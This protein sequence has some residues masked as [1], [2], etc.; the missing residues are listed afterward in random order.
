VSSSWADI[1]SQPE[2]DPRIDR[3]RLARPPARP[4]Q[5]MAGLRTPEVTGEPGSGAAVAYVSALSPREV[6]A[7]RYL[8][9]G[10]TDLQAAHRMGVTRHT[11]DTYLRRIKAK[12]GVSSRAGLIRLALD[13][14]A[15]Q[16]DPR[17]FDGSAS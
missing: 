12:R 1:H 11:F 2:T 7:L 4:I 5:G 16:R 6:E 17:D 9:R 10:L 14:H 8:V 15:S 13:L 3:S